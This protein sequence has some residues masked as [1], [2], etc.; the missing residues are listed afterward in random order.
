M[1]R[2][3]TLLFLLALTGTAS[4]ASNANTAMNISQFL[5]HQERLREDL[6]ESSKFAHLDNQSKQRI[7]DSQDVLF[8][9]LRDRNSIGE[10]SDD[11]RLQVFNAQNVIAAVLDDAEADRPICVQA[12]R[13]GSHLHNID[14]WSKRER[15]AQRDSARHKLIETR[16][17]ANEPGC[18]KG[19]I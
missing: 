16:P 7:Y 15:E 17:C 4:A 5:A 8:A 6:A 9:L 19:G 18:T 12:P 11:E 3:V 2:L 1:I 14:C 10:L 13:L